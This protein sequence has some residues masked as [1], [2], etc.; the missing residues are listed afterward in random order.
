MGLAQMFIC[1]FPQNNTEKSKEL[2]GQPNAHNKILF[3]Y[4]KEGNSDSKTW[5][6]LEDNMP[7]ETNQ[8]QM[9]DMYDSTN[10][11]YLK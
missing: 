1:F 11:W 10:V 9:T 8:V 4:K 3:N 6:N 2:F 7:S 5:T